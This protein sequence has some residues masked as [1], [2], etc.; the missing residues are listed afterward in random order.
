MV[1]Q[2]VS[3][4][5]PAFN[6]P[7]FI[8]KTILFLLTIGFPIWLLFAWVYEMT[9]EGIKKTE[10][11]DQEKSILPK[12]GSKFNKLI[13]VV[14]IFVVVFLLLNPSWKTKMDIEDQIE[15]IDLNSKTRDL[16]SNIKALDFY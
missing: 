2:V 5:L 15:E 16:T 9:P 13:I 6:A 4:F 3:I 10:E 11:V 1:A 7:P 14:L 12:T 8:L